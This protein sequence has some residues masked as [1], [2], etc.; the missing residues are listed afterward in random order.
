MN[1]VFLMGN[2]TRDPEVR[3]VQVSGRNTSVASFTIAVNRNFKKNNGEWGESTDF[4]ACEAWD[5]GAEQLGE[6]ASKGD[7]VLVDDARL[8]TDTWETD[9]KKHSRLVVRVQHFKIIKKT[10]KD[11]DEPSTSVENES[12]DF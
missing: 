7:L 10:R 5:S 2:L 1:K 8:K 9:G 3:V 4:V 12:P 6:R 11:Q